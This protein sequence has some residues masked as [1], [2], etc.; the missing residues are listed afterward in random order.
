MY[1]TKWFLLVA[2]IFVASLLTANIIAV[3]LV[4][5]GELPILG[6]VVLP[7][8]II[9]FPVSYIIGDILTEVYGFAAARRVI[10]LGFLANVVL[11]VFVYLGQL[12]PPAGFWEG[13]DAY[14][15]VLGFTARLL[16]ASFAAYLVGEFTNSLILAKLKIRMKGRFLAV[17]TIGS[18]VVG[19]GIDSAIFITIA[20]ASILP[21]S[22]LMTLV[23][24]QWLFKVSYEAFAT[25]VT[26]LVVSFLKRSE[27]ID[28]F[29]VDADFNPLAVG[30]VS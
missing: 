11:V 28:V 15:A 6:N 2:T 21:A 20:F 17:R 8:A 22:D 19:Q 23:M 14:E 18:T 27:G 9:V 10:W 16:V 30:S 5:F 12:L 4:S 7:A 26:Y 25:P 24:H 13:Q 1:G 29:D 3:K